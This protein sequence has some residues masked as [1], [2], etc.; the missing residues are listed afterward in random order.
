MEMEQVQPYLDKAIELG[1]GYL[2]KVVLAIITLIVGFWIIGR[3]TK[4]L[5][6]VLGHKAVD[7]T[8]QKFMTSFVE[9]LLK[10][11]LLVAAHFFFHIRPIR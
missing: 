8:L 5:N 6:R 7:D 4:G 10:L 3:I 1:M 2:P 9:V 11:L